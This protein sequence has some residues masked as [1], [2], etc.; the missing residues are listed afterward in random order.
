MQTQIT[1]LV[2]IQREHDRLKKQLKQLATYEVDVDDLIK[3]EKKWEDQLCFEPCA[4]P[5]L[6]SLSR[7][8]ELRK[9]EAYPT[10][11]YND[12]IYQI[13][14]YKSASWAL[15]HRAFGN[16]LAPCLNEWGHLRNQHRKLF[17][18]DMEPDKK[19]TISVQADFLRAQLQALLPTPDTVS[20]TSEQVITV[21]KQQA[22]DALFK[23][24]IDQFACMSK[25]IEEA[26]YPKHT[27]PAEVV[28]MQA[29]RS[30][31]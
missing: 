3:L 27:S 6:A 1:A 24:L 13:H 29:Y 7:L 20:P 5:L 10:S 31:P 4:P 18:Q 9:N 21:A 2:I 19:L 22:S 14:V 16:S 12:V 26:Q 11:A 30:T 8:I 15:L 25:R 17:K 23:E 28:N